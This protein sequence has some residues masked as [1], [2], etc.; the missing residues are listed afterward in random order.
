[1][2]EAETPAKESMDMRSLRCFVAVSLLAYGLCASGVLAST[3]VAEYSFGD[4]GNLA[5]D[6]SGN[7]NDAVV[8]GTVTQGT[9]PLGLSSG[10]FNGAGVIERLSDLS[11]FSEANGFSYALW[12]DVPEIGGYQGLVSQDSGG[13]CVNRLMVLNTGAGPDV[14][15]NA[16]AHYDVLTS[17]VT[18]YDTWEFLV[19]TADNEA[20][21]GGNAVAHV[22]LNGALSD[23]IDLPYALSNVDPLYTYLGAGEGGGPYRFNGA[24]ADVRIYQGAL[25]S[26]EVASLYNSYYGSTVPEPGTLLLLVGGLGAVLLSRARRRS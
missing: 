3:L 13:C 18:A 17:T 9:G 25:T 23:T 1:M 21:N 19:L 11:G 24:L 14:F 15:V 6:T 16:G 2:P 26:S 4:S 5:L 8:A 7:G 20:G 12:A 10:V 22:Y